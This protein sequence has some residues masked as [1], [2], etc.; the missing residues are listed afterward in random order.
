MGISTEDN[1]LVNMQ[2]MHI[3]NMD[4][5]PNSSQIYRSLMCV[6]WNTQCN[7]DVGQQTGIAGDT[8]GITEGWSLCSNSVRSVSPK[9]GG[10]QLEKIC[11]KVQR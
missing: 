7:E 2:Q 3:W 8:L 9:S 1:T 10:M 6:I 5:K 11:I 4:L